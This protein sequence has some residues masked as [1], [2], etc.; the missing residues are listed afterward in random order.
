MMLGNL[1]CDPAPLLPSQSACR[2]SPA[3]FPNLLSACPPLDH[4][5][6]QLDG[7][8]LP[9]QKYQHSFPPSAEPQLTPR[10]VPILPPPPSPYTETPPPHASLPQADTPSP[11]PPRSSRPDTSHPTPHPPPRYQPPAPSPP[12]PPALTPPSPGHSGRPAP[13]AQRPGPKRVRPR[14][15]ARRRTTTSQPA[16][17]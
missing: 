12:P 17:G 13:T 9:H 2:Q 8:M 1:T 3:K 7:T 16:V 10:D 14:A 6:P 15:T 11:H 5:T 4:H